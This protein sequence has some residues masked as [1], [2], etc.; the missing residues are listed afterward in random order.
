MLN[1]DPLY[2]QKVY[3]HDC[4]TVHFAEVQNSG[5]IVCHGVNYYFDALSTRTHYARRLGKGFSL[6][7]MTH[8][9]TLTALTL[10]WQI[11][12]ERE[13]VDANQDW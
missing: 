12:S 10:D 4:M 2:F 9:E 3:C 1:N 11:A 8:P 13:T 7:P 6:I 5:R